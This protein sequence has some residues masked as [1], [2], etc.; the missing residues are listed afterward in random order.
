MAPCIPAFQGASPPL[1]PRHILRRTLTPGSFPA[2]L[3]RLGRSARLNAHAHATPVATTALGHRYLRPRCDACAAAKA[4]RHT[5]LRTSRRRCPSGATPNDRASFIGA[6][7][8]T[9]RR[10][11]SCSDTYRPLKITRTA[12]LPLSASAPQPNRRNR[13]NSH[14]CPRLREIRAHRIPPDRSPEG[15]LAEGSCPA[16]NAVQDA[17]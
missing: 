5:L 4:R 13:Y 15:A 8:P 11:A 16:R 12:P 9:Y 7:I 1:D 3:A 14:C 17:R 6:F 10:C 2:A